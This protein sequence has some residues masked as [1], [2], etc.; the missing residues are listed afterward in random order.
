MD[1]VFDLLLA[2]QLREQWALAICVVSNYVR[3]R[4]GGCMFRYAT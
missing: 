4:A 1:Q 3:V 2:W